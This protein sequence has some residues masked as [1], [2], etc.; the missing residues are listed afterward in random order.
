VTVNCDCCDVYVCDLGDNYRLSI[1]YWPIQRGN[2]A[3]FVHYDVVFLVC[4]LVYTCVRAH[5]VA[6]CVV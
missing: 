5:A 2:Q 3:T 1:D 6:V 4:F